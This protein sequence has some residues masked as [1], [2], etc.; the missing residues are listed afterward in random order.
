ML[1]LMLSFSGLLFSLMTTHLAS[2]VLQVQF[3]LF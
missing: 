3:E 1:M 2:E